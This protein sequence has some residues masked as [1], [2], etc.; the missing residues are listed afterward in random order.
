[1]ALTCPICE[2][3]GMNCICAP[4][5]QR[6]IAKVQVAPN[7]IS[8]EERLIEMQDEPGYVYG[9]MTGFDN[10]EDFSIVGLYNHGNALE[11]Q[12]KEVWTIEE[13]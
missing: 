1:M 12:Y 4:K 8:A 2:M 10:A 11:G 9:Y 3:A 5:F 7:R 6:L 13:D